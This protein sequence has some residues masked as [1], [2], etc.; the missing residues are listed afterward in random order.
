[1]FSG[2]HTEFA[3]FFYLQ[4]LERFLTWEAGR[5]LGLTASSIE[6]SGTCL[7]L[8]AQR[9]TLANYSWVGGWGDLLT[10]NYSRGQIMYLWR[11]CFCLGRRA[12]ISQEK[13]L[14][15]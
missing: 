8:E 6:E 9:Q 10:P 15:S 4:T 14:S 5:T 3:H 7:M 13:S 11:L 1:M 12:V 2:R